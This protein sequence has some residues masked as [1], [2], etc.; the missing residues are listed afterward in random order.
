MLR[1]TDAKDVEFL[2]S[3]D[4]RAWLA[5]GLG[6][7]AARLGEPA[8]RPRVLGAP[9]IE[10]PRDMDAVFE[11]V[12]GIQAEIGQREVDFALVE[13][14]G[15]GGAEK[16]LPPGFAPLGDPA[17]QLM[18]TFVRGNELALLVVPALLR[19]PALVHASVARELG[20]IAIH[21]AGGHTVEPEEME[22]DAEIAA[23]ALGMGVWVANGAYVYE[24]A[25]CGGGCGLDLKSMRT[26][27]SMP[28]ACFGLA[29][30]LQR[31][32]IAPRHAAKHL[33]S[34]QKA[35]FKKSASFVGHQPELLAL[36]SPAKPAIA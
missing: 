21:R 1:F 35:A 16:H 10:K 19:V 17:G 34:T 30:D 27:L 28:E 22:A 20:R 15:A 2:P 33:E 23:I 18:H 7:L 5:E 9:P 11:L 29:L 24:N 12:C 25:C 13:L 8:A 6:E 3:E 14:D 32:G 26:G 31:K 36:A 4:A